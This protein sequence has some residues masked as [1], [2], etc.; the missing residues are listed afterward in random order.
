MNE[1]Q[2]M[3]KKEWSVTDEGYQLCPDCFESM[4]YNDR[5]E[6]YNHCIDCKWI[7]AYLTE[8]LP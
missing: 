4:T 1:N 6:T 5:T 3:L 2:K 8:K 7:E